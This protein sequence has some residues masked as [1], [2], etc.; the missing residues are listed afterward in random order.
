MQAVVATMLNCPTLQAVHG[1]AAEES[2]SACPAAHSAHTVT[3]GA[4][5]VPAAHGMHG[6][7][8]FESWSVVP[9]SHAVQV[10]APAAVYEPAAHSDALPSHGVAA[11]ASLS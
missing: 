9:A 10:S 4:A 7:T 1:V 6:V 5:Y 3:L 11:F 8:G 2:R